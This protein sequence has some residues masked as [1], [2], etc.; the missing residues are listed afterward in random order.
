[1]GEPGP[2]DRTRRYFGDR[3]C[4]IPSLTTP[5]TGASEPQKLGLSPNCWITR[6]PKGICCLLPLNTTAC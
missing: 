4:H 1:M 2:Q 5:S 6:K 3:S